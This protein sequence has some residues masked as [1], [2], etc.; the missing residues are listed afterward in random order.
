[1][2]LY[3]T[4]TSPY[5][6]LAM[7]ARLEKGLGDQVELVWTRTRIPN[8]PILDFNPSGRLPFLWLDDAMGL[9][10]TDLIVEFFDSLAEPR[11]FAPPSGD[12]Y[13][14]FRRLQTMA[15]SM[16][17]GVSVWAREIVRPVEEQS[18]GIIEHER[19]RAQRLAKF[20][21]NAVA[22]PPFTG[23]LNMVQLLLFCALDVERRLP[24]FDWRT[25]HPNLVD[26]HAR[27]AALP[28]VIGSLPPK[29]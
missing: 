24:A 2:K 8:D 6:R 22:A 9:E 4:P 3:V 21:D 14:A 16:L 20:F 12:D 10:D 1:M 15:R 27:V 19:Q 26:W 25:G 17:D 7:I 29:P 5:A 18:P 11:R 28:S 23:K 13:W